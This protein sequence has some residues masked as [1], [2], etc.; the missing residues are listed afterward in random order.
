MHE[1]DVLLRKCHR[2]TGRKGGLILQKGLELWSLRLIAK[3]EML[4]SNLDVV[5][6]VRI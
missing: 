1:N 2:D 6:Q 5:K 4:Y 3:G